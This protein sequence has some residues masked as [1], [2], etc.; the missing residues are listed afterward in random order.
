[1]TDEMSSA[2]YRRLMG[3]SDVDT[4]AELDAESYRRLVEQGTANGLLRNLDSSKVDTET[5]AKTEFGEWLDAVSPVPVLREYRGIPGRRF[6]FD[7][8]VGEPLNIAFEYDGVA[9]HTTQAGAWRDAEKGNLAQLAGIMFIRV[10][11]RTLRDG[12]GYTVANKALELR[13]A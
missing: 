1:M 13:A 5:P 11:A 4:M 6:R 10:N 3:L 12:S 8:F 7:W 2:H 9:H